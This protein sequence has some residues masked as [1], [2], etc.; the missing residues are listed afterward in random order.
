MSVTLLHR[1]D[2][3]QLTAD[4]NE[5]I[6]EDRTAGDPVAV[7]FRSHNETVGKLSID[8]EVEGVWREIGLLI[9][10]A[11]ERGRTDPAHRGALEVRALTHIPGRPYEDADYREMCAIRHD[12]LTVNGRP[13]PA[14]A[15]PALLRS[16]DGRLVLAAQDDGNLVLYADG[17]PIRALFGVEPHQVW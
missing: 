16:L 14:P 10:K 5:V 15:T 7:R 17:V 2:R 9:F 8:V 13:L 12:G 11:D 4:G 6:L 3:G 1:D